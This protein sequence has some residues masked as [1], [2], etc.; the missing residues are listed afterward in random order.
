MPFQASDTCRKL[1]AL[2]N[3]SKEL[4]VDHSSRTLSIDTINSAKILCNSRNFGIKDGILD[5]LESL[6][7]AIRSYKP[8][9]LLEEF[10]KVEEFVITLDM[11]E[12]KASKPKTPEIP[13]ADM[14]ESQY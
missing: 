2:L 6:S 4:S 3:N 14:M 5:V 8:E 10:H 13:Y 12:I 11:G 1:I 9:V 7:Y